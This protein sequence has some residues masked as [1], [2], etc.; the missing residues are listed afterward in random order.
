MKLQHFIYLSL[1]SHSVL[2]CNVKSLS[3]KWVKITPF[4]ILFLKTSMVI[5][6][7]SDLE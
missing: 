1:K 5:S 7:I 3:S 6:G 4:T 2:L